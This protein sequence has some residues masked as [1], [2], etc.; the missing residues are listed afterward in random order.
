MK[1]A[2][3]LALVLG[4]MVALQGCV[5]LG[6][7][8]A[9]GVGAK[10]ATDPRS[11]GT[12]IDDETLEERVIYAIKK[13]E[14]IKAEGRVNVVAYSGRVLLIGQ[15]PQEGLKDIAKSLA[16]GVEGVKPDQVYN[17]LR[18]GQPIT[19]GQISKDAWI[20]SQV[21]SKLLINS[22]VK[23]TAV[24]VITENAEVFLMGNLTR[25][26]ADAAAQVAANTSGVTKVVK[27]FK[28]LD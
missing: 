13:D 27:V 3:R 19:A 7:G 14:Q 6:I 26:Q 16:E 23:M 21:K 1:H 2:I 24:K 12:Q 22:D 20:T 28:Y 9:V 8:A 25:S 15:V 10:V 5:A 11:A 18:I 4:T 17:E